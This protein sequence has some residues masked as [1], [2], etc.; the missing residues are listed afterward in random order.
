MSQGLGLKFG[1]LLKY[2]NARKALN[3]GLSTSMVADL[4]WPNICSLCSTFVSLFVIFDHIEQ[5]I[6]LWLCLSDQ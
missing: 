2:L 1:S 6:R 3:I 5:L 4:L